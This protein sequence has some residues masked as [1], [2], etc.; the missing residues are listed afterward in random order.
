MRPAPGYADFRTPIAGLYQASSATHGGGGVT[1]IPG[2]NATRQIMRDRARR[3]GVVRRRIVAIAARS[4]SRCSSSARAGCRVAA[5]MP[6]AGAPQPLR[7]TV[8]TL[9]TIGS[10]DPR[11][12]DS[13]I[14]REVWNLQYPTLTALDPK[15]LDP[16][17][18][19]AIAWSP[20]PNGTRLALHAAARPHVVRRQTR[21]RRR[22]RV[23][24]RPRARRPLAVRRATNSTGLVAPG[25]RPRTVAITSSSTT[26]RPPGLLLERRPAARVRRRS[27]DLNN[28][29]ATLGVADGAWHVVATTDD[30][31]ELGVLVDPAARRST[32]SSSA[33][34]PTPTR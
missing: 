22:R 29:I 19:L 2:L 1:G 23:L 12:G 15:T 5:G 30:S 14:A 33:P 4:R 20:L 16:R 9:G 18:G 13:A 21:H 27:P 17:A 28:D 24:A 3:G 26:S 11:T 25:A 8:G 6:G 10:L 32:R 34:I 7:L 31:V